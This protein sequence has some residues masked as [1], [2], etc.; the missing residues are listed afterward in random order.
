MEHTL[1]F[2]APP[3]TTV[4][5][6]F[7]TDV[8]C[9]DGRCGEL[10][11]VVVDPTGPRITHLVTE[12]HHHHALARLV[13]AELARVDE[14]AIRLSCSRLEYQAFQAAEEIVVLPTD[15]VAG[16]PA[17][18]LFGPMWPATRPAQTFIVRESIPGGEV[19]LTRST[20]IHLGH[21]RFCHLHGLIAEASKGRVTHAILGLGHLRHTREVL[22]AIGSDAEID[23][24]GLRLSLERYAFSAL[25][26]SG[27]SPDR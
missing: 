24:R 16:F 10:S 5:Y 3:T 21:I 6:R 11:R 20:L 9:V 22:V 8:E 18:G 12:P 15:H 26:A 23:Q 19:E 17:A 1:T 7:G 27:R 4:H 25:L 2:E 14:R 13:P